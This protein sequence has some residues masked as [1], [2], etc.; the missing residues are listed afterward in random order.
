MQIAGIIGNVWKHYG[1]AQWDILGAYCGKAYLGAMTS[2]Q[3]IMVAKQ[4]L[5]DTS[6]GTQVCNISTT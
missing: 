1:I 2:V 6:H 4:W 5:A 3:Q